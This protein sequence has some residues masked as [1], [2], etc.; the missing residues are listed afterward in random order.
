MELFRPKS[1]ENGVSPLAY[2][3]Y[4]AESIQDML[5]SRDQVVSDLTSAI[6][7]WK[8]KGLRRY[9]MRGDL[10]VNTSVYLNTV[11][12]NAPATLL[13]GDKIV[14]IADSTGE[15]EARLPSTGL[16]KALSASIF[17]MHDFRPLNLEVLSEAPWQGVVC[18]RSS[19]FLPDQSLD[20]KLLLAVFMP[21]D[22]ITQLL[23]AP[24]L[25]L[26]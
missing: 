5:E 17:W 16:E 3:A 24:R 26:A 7:K 25:R 15:C 18:L 8:K 19:Y 21:H 23:A 14:N 12:S 13:E 6:D 9:L 11:R 1:L 2:T 20:T 4:T 22:R 10:R